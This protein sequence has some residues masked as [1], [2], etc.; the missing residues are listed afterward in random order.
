MTNK[1][2]I[3]VIIAP[4][5]GTNQLRYILPNPPPLEDFHSLLET[6]AAGA[7]MGG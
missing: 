6:K 7:R 3:H 1:G 2:R 5:D 4:V